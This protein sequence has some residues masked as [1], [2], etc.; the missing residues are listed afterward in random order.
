MGKERKC[1]RKKEESEGGR[2]GVRIDEAGKGREKTEQRKGR[3]ERGVKKESEG[4]RS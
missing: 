1:K 3:R 4:G 2:S